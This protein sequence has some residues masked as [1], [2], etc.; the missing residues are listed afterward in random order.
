LNIPS[1]GGYDTDPNAADLSQV[2]DFTQSPNFKFTP[3]AQQYSKS[4]LKKLSKSK[5]AQPPDTY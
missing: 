3:F 1:L 2:F 4:Y 5:Y